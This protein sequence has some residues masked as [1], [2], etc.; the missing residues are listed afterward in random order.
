M[1]GLT[2]RAFAAACI[3]TAASRA[4]AARARGIRTVQ[5]A[6]GGSAPALGMGSWRLGQ[7]RRPAAEEEQALRVGLELGM[8]LIDT[9]E[10]YGQ[11][12]SEELIGRVISGRRERTFLVSKVLPSH[13]S[14][15]G[16]RNACSGSLDRLGTRTLD[17]YLL[18]WRGGIR[19]L[20]PV[21]STFEALRSE[22]KIGRWGVSNFTISDMD[23][24]FQVEEGSRCATN[25]VLYNLRDR[26]AER[27]VLPWC[28]QR[29]IA[30]MAYSPLGS[31]G[32]LLRNP[33]LAR[34]AARHGVTPAAVALAWTMR[35]GH[36]ISI[37]ELGSAVHVR[38]NAAAST[39]KLEAVDLD[40]LDQAFPA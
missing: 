33:A 14:P 20:R 28:R 19:N 24:L 25:Q 31:G 17:L 5:L 26:Q 40:E 30:I 9:A 12:R 8:S 21:V 39:L 37:P 32:G 16:I 11:G 4:R 3:A 34:I 15:N 10:M 27:H 6:D 22:G 13:A 2:R 35:D 38:E 1:V 36:T 7:G 23:D 18:H 29:G